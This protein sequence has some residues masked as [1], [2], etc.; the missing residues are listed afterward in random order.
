MRGQR[1]NP[2]KADLHRWREMFAERLRALGIDAEATRQV[3]RGEIRNPEALWRRKAAERERQRSASKATATRPAVRRT[4]V[5]WV[6]AWGMI[7]KTLNSSSE[8]E[9]RNPAA[10]I[11]RFLNNTPAVRRYWAE[12]EGVQPLKAEQAR[13]MPSESL[14]QAVQSIHSR[15]G[16][17]R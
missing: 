13:C 6:A 11:V 16:P 14:D 15:Q 1:L 4:K 7:A 17:E 12:R 8:P 2:R 5:E 10:R 9:D 3:T